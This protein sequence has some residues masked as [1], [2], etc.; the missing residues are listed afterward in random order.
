MDKQV[1]ND[2]S[3][4]LTS[5]TLFYYCIRFKGTTQSFLKPRS[6]W[7]LPSGTTTRYLHI[8]PETAASKA[9]IFL[10]VYTNIAL[11]ELKTVF[12]KYPD[13]EIQILARLDDQIQWSTI[14]SLKGKDITTQMNLENI[15]WR[16]RSQT[17]KVTYRMIP[18]V[19]NI[20]NRYSYRDTRASLVAQWQRI[21]L[22]MQE[23]QIQ[24]LGWEDPLE[25]DM[26]THSTILAW[27]IPQ[28]EEPG[29]Q[30][31]KEQDMI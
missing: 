20:W 27:R 3:F 9:L 29:E 11:K 7:N 6:S 10:W 2:V 30:L 15:M 23:T 19:W 16:E 21:C 22:P 5:K 18:F 26:A 8:S 25:E 17:Q 28:T 12:R 24:C 31:C 14:Q 13:K 1:L 4:T